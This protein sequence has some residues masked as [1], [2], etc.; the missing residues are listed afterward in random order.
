MHA[1]E[2]M[3]ADFEAYWRS[4][5]EKHAV[6][7]VGGY[8]PA[9]K[10]FNP[11][12]ISKLLPNVFM[13]ERSDPKTITVRLTG[14]GLDQ[15]LERPLVNKNLMDIY[16]G[17]ELD[18]FLELYGDVVEKPCGAAIKRHVVLSNGVRYDVKSVTLPLASK[19]GDVRYLLGMVG[20]QIAHLDPLGEN[21]I[22]AGTH[23]S[24]CFYLD[25]GA[26]V[27]EQLPVWP[28]KMQPSQPLV[29]A[30]FTGTARKI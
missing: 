16:R 24:D 20:G 14:S 29:E 12:A 1:S 26:G 6:A 30:D 13:L 28:A 4:M 3:F 7:G 9:R 11:M 5:Q 8:V 15:A 18:F 21:T 22:L 25:I 17:D 19:E 2:Q 10:L 23:I 27:P